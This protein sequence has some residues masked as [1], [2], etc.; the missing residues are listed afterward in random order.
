MNSRRAHRSFCSLSIKKQYQWTWLRPQ[1]WPRFYPKEINSVHLQM[2]FKDSRL[3]RIK[4]F[5]CYFQSFPNCLI[6]GINSVAS[7]VLSSSLTAPI[8]FARYLVSSSFQTD[9]A[10]NRAPFK[11]DLTCPC[12]T[13]R[14]SLI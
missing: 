11:A 3:T 10:S 4:Y 6:A 1:A 5:T 9:I 13:V 12:V 8:D 2:R 7:F 14:S